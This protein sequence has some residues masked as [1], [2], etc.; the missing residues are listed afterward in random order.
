ML[1]THDWKS[2]VIGFTS[3]HKLFAGT[4]LP[5]CHRILDPLLVV[6]TVCALGAFEGVLRWDGFDFRGLAATVPSTLTAPRHFSLH[7]STV[8]LTS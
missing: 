3:L 2:V 5:L 7:V 8:M 6:E 1:L 4:Q